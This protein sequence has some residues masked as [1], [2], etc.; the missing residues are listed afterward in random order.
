MIEIERKFL[1]NGE[2]F[3]EDAY[4]SFRIKQGFLNSHPDRT[5]RVR[6]T[7]GEAF[8]TI[9]GRNNKS[10][11]TRFEWE[12]EINSAEAEELLKR[13]EPGIIDKTRYLVKVGDHLFEVDKFY[14]DN[15]GLVVAEIELLQ[16]DEWFEKPKWLAVE[17]TGKPEYYNSQ[18]SKHPYKNWE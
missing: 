18:L 9:K 3:K 15:E 16:E 17:V 14:G 2:G 11:L 12:K 1:V 6:I 4:D 13:C 7:D 5:V 8:L 10:G